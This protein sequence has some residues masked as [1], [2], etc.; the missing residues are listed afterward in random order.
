ML[1]AFER[2]DWRQQID[3]VMTGYFRDVG[4]I[5]AAAAFIRRIRDAR[6]QFQVLVDG[7]IVVAKSRNTPPPVRKPEIA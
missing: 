2:P 1:S 3:L 6:Q 5:E 4:Q 7:E